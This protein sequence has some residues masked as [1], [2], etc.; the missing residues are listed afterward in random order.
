M[1][2]Q[3]ILAQFPTDLNPDEISEPLIFQAGESNEFILTLNASANTNWSIPNS[4]SA[5]LIVAVNGDWDNYNQDIVLYAGNTNHEYNVSLGYLEEGEHSIEFKFDDYKSTLGA[6]HI[7]IESANIIN[8]ETSNVDP[9]VF[10][11][12]PILYGRDLLSWDE[13]THTDIPIIMSYYISE[14]DCSKIIE[15]HIIFSNEDSR[16]GLGL[17]DLMFSYGRTTDIE[18]VYRVELDCD[19]EIIDEQFQGP[20]HT[21]TNFNGQKIGQHPILKNATLNCNFTDIGISDYKFFLVP[22][23][24]QSS[25][26]RQMLMDENSWSYRIMGEELINE[27]RYELEPNPSTIEMSDVRNYLYIE[28]L[29]RVFNGLDHTLDLAIKFHGDCNYYFHNHQ[30]EL[31]QTNASSFNPNISTAD[32]TSIE[33]MHDFDINNIEALGFILNIESN[34]FNSI[35]FF[36]EDIVKL[37]Y[38]D[39]NY[40]PIDIPIN[41]YSSTLNGENHEIWFTINE[42]L[43][44][45]DC[46]GT[47]DGMAECDDCNVCDGNNLD[48]DDCG[49]CFGDNLNIDCN[50]EC[51]GTSAVDDCGVCD[52]DLEND[53]LTCS[54]CTDS[55]ADNYD[56]NAIFYD[57]SCIYS[58]N[59]F[60]VPTEYAL[61]QDAIFY[62]SSGDTV[63]VGDGI[64]YENLNF[65]D[66]SI[67]LTSESE[68]DVQP[69]IIGNDSLSTITIENSMD[70][71]VEGLTISNGFGRG[72]SFDDF[73][74]LAADEA[75]FDSLVTQV[76]RGGGISIINSNAYLKNLNITD[77]TSQNV[78]AGLGLINSTV[79]IESSQIINNS[80][81]DGDALGGGGIAINGGEVTIRNS[82]ISNNLVGSNLYSLN[83]GGGILCGFSFGESPL[84]LNM[85]NTTIFNNSANIGAGLGALS[86]NISLERA[87]ISNNTGNYGSAISMGEPLGLVVGDINMNV[88]N[89][90]IADNTGLLTVGLINSA[91]LNV[92]NS[93]VWNNDGDYEFSPMPNND[94]LNIDAHYS[95]FTN[96]MVGEGNLNLNPQF[97][98][99]SYDL[100]PASPAI[101]AGIDYFSFNNDFINIESYYGNAPDIGAYEYEFCGIGADGDI[102]ADGGLD[103]LDILQTVNIIMGFT[104]IIDNQLCIVDINQDNLLDILD[105]I[106]MVS[107][108]LSE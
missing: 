35:E 86:G 98:N 61:I 45:I 85:Y 106:I 95:I 1:L 57:D 40:V 105:I 62:A 25:G 63:E 102:N 87:V 72:V 8:I 79:T 3:L 53:N 9:D 90:T 77:N 26:T 33:L 93:I 94:Q 46:L 64:Y 71:I 52:N 97:F 19:G 68:L 21:T 13:S 82:Y 7:H 103:I 5:T 56:T 49:I 92:L 20:S 37:F 91:Y 15:Y 17:A 23:Q 101:D 6:E 70:A 42:N 39:D 89:S 43:M 88:I 66:K 99:N 14:S 44:N 28:Y 60:L 16:L 10:L 11:H 29:A 4:E 104:D 67:V 69:Q 32:R 2:L 50:G 34:N 12:S 76:L 55:N 108:I 100:S 47:P 51:F 59:I 24:Q 41:F 31:F 65:L 22:I 84:S 54:G 73:L 38:L 81:P 27:N 30:S 48:I 36:I 75:A 58:D 80:I 78:G 83:G 107:I 18:W 96:P 74:S